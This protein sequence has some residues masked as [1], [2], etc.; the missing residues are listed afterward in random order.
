[1]DFLQGVPSHWPPRSFLSGRDSQWR[2]SETW[3]TLGWPVPFELLASVSGA[4]LAP[5]QILG[6]P[7]CWDTLY[8]VLLVTLQGS[9]FEQVATKCK[10]FQKG[11]RLG[12][13]LKSISFQN[14]STSVF[15]LTRRSIC[16]NF[17]FFKL[18]CQL[19]SQLMTTCDNL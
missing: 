13:S 6:W 5:N 8:V 1:M 12:H 3:K 10:S 18:P 19:N 16:D 14:L 7:V 4:I 11:G 15:Y 2:L 17:G 9:T